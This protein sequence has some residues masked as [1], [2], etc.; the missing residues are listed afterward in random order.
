MNK[1]NIPL[2]IAISAVSGG[3]KTTVSN[4]LN[5]NWKNTKVLHFDEYD[6]KGPDDIVNWIDRGGDP[7]EWDLTPFIKNLDR[8]ITEPFDFIVLDFPFSY[9]HNQVCDFIDFSVFIDTPL[10]IALARR[11]IRDHAGSSTENLSH[12]M[13]H[14][15]SRGRKAYLSM[16]NTIKP[17]VDMVIDGEMKASEM[18]E[19]ILEQIK[20]MQSQLKRSSS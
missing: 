13:D 17:N 1:E 8:L 7:N 9:M 5:R 20:Q 14:Y 16:L 2:I 4:Y 18:A 19:L 11:V 15:I 12:E 10:D 6:F 3:G